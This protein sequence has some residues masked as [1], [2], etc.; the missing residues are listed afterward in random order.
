MSTPEGRLSVAE[1]AELINR[2]ESAG[3]Q[4]E[5]SA[6]ERS[7]EGAV[8]LVF[9]SYPTAEDGHVFLGPLVRAARARATA[10]GLDVV[11]VAPSESSSADRWLEDQA[12]RRCIDYGARGIVVLGGADG[13]PDVLG[14]LEQALPSVFVEYEPLGGRSVSIGIDNVASFGEAV[15]HLLG[16]GRSRVATVTGPLDTTVGAERLAGYRDT[17]N[18]AGY[19]VRN[20]YIHTGD[21]RF[22]SGYE[23]MQRF[24]ALD[25][26][27]DALAA[28]CDVQAVGAMLALD[29]AGVRCPDDVAVTGFD[30]AAFAARMSPSLTTVRQ[31]A[32]AMGTAAIDALIEMFE[33]P[34]AT[35]SRIELSGELVVRE[36]CGAV[37]PDGPS[38][39]PTLRIV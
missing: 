3:F 20:E 28:A 21:Y 7:V 25:D 35:A 37:R 8:A 38:Q 23:A 24:L 6:V 34:N 36:S 39:P 18:R 15:T 26:P 4:M 32:V 30:D 27:P 17:L 11:F 12:V 31:P 14:R 22:H 1:V 19:P 16:A 5:A 33:N 29:E 13:N 9:T 10:V 2:D